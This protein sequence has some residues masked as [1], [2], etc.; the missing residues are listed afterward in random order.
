MNLYVPSCRYLKDVKLN[1]MK[2][3]GVFRL[4]E[5]TYTSKRLKHMTSIETQICLNQLVF[6]AF[7]EWLPKGELPYQISSEKYVALMEE[8]MFILK[9]EI[10]FRRPIP[11]DIDIH[12][13]IEVQ[14]LKKIKNTHFVFLKYTLEQGKSFG[15]MKLAMTIDDHITNDDSIISKL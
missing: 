3:E 4:E 7:G 9:S 11:T 8:N 5:T 6:Y 10:G 15:S 1:N 14:D 2:A 12:A 13:N